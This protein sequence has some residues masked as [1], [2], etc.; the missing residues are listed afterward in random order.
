MVRFVDMEHNASKDVSIIKNL[1]NSEKILVYMEKYFKDY[2]FEEFTRIVYGCQHEIDNHQYAI[3]LYGEGFDIYIR[4]F[5]K[6]E[7]VKDY[8][9]RYIKSDKIDIGQIF[10]NGKRIE[11]HVEIV[12]NS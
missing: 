8:I 11:F 1:T 7:D 12:L 9:C 3:I 2:E 4:C 6:N 5:N 10:Y